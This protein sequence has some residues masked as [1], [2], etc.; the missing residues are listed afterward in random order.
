ME[1]SRQPHIL[2]SHGW[3]LVQ[4]RKGSLPL[5]VK[6]HTYLAPQKST[7]W[8]SSDLPY[9]M[10]YLSKFCPGR[11]LRSGGVGEGKQASSQFPVPA[12]PSFCLINKDCYQMK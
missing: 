8:A 10:S 5:K 4:Q 11:G 9:S 7:P 3:R 1:G 12:S 2:P 6:T